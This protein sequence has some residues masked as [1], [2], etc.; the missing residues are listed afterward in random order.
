MV[1]VMVTEVSDSIS[2]S[3][4][5]NAAVVRQQEYASLIAFAHVPMR[6][7]QRAQNYTW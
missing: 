7:R 5:Q 3:L 1:M 4:F 2:A 6:V